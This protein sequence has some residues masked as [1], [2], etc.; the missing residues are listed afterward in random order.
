MPDSHLQ[1][2]DGIEAVPADQLLAAHQALIDR[3]RLAFGVDRATFDSDIAPLLGR[4]AACVHRLPATA[5]GHFSEPGGLLRLGLEVAFFALQGTDAHIFA[6]RSTI[7]E[8]RH[9]EPRWQL[10]TFIAGLCCELHRT[11]GPLL[12]LDAHGR[13]WP[14][15]L[16]PLADWLLDR[17][18][19][20][21]CVRWRA[22][23]LPVQAQ[24]LFVLPHVVPAKVMRFLGEDNA[25]IVP[26]LL[27]GV[28]GLS[29]YRDRNVLDTLV[30][31]ALA[32]VIDRDLRARAGRGAAAPAGTHVA[33]CLV[34]AMQ[35]LVRGHAA[36][37]PNR[38]KSRLWLGREGLYVTW[39]QAA[40]DLQ[41]A[42]E[43]AQLAGMPRSP[44]AMLDALL[45]AGVLEPRD[46]ASA[47]WPIQIP[48]SQAL[49][50]A[51]RLSS[52]DILLAG[53]TPCPAPL[54]V[55]LARDPGQPPARARPARA[56]SAPAAM[57]QLPLPGTEPP[58][59]V[60]AGDRPDGEAPEKPPRKSDAPRRRTVTLDPPRRLDPLVRDAVAKA[61]SAAGK[62]PRS[63]ASRTTADGFFV[64]IDELERQ[65]IDATEALRTLGDAG[66]LVGAGGRTKATLA[67]HEIDGEPCT[68]L[69][70]RPRFIQ[71]LG[72]AAF[73]PAGSPSGD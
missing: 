49:A 54:E 19:D 73:S 38:D 4:Y 55:P 41:A 47:L 50:E 44:E 63:L 10:A 17:G 31:R 5:G 7:S 61:V 11:I 3:I 69:V 16:M 34:E 30:R 22:D 32:L 8:R 18:L 2:E 48:G 45:D 9:L 40:V 72:L 39:P 56:P 33:R 64:R 70:I 37:V 62:E 60:E 58:A 21:Y 36:W 25:V 67:T 26:Y 65:G 23:V 35:G 29:L 15:C 71:G 43:A 1:D 51:V 14:A 13:E 42:L 52:P 20:R 57:A 68:G 46:G 24:G 6:G 27:A 28:G 53:V 12:V 59:A 66:M